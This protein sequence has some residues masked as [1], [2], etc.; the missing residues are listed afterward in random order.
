MYE[1]GAIASFGSLAGNGNGI[2]TPSRNSQT[3][4]SAMHACCAGSRLLA[5]ARNSVGLKAQAL[6]CLEGGLALGQQ[7][8]VLF[9]SA[10]VGLDQEPRSVR[11]ISR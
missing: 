5:L 7:R 6:A 1:G 3:R 9:I 8:A 2:S 4:C 10:V 11:G